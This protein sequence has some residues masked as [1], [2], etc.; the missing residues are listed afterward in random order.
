MVGSCVTTTNIVSVGSCVTTLSFFF[1]L[2]QQRIDLKFQS[3]E[4]IQN[5]DSVM[6]V[7]I[8]QSFQSYSIMCI[9]VC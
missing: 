6:C 3:Y 7:S 8:I 9:E 1:F 2:L 4:C 5:D